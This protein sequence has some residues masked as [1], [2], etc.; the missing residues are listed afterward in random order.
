MSTVLFFTDDTEVV[1]VDFGHLTVVAAIDSKAICTKPL[2]LFPYNLLQMF[3]FLKPFSWDESKFVYD[4][5]LKFPT[6][7]MML[8]YPVEVIPVNPESCSDV[9]QFYLAVEFVFMIK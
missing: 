5:P 6:P 4:T 8:D 9:Y 3:V 2:N 7:C 1:L